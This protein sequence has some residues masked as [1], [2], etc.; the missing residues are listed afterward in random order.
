MSLELALKNKKKK[1]RASQ[2]WSLYI[3]SNMEI[4]LLCVKT[5]NLREHENNAGV[6]YAVIN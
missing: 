4:F 2:D 5:Q 3:A 1:I 6:I